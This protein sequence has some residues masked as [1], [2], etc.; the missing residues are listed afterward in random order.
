MSGTA[1]KSSQSFSPI[2]FC[3]IILDIDN[4]NNIYGHPAGNYVLKEVAKLIQL[5]VP[6]RAQAGRIGGDAFLALCVPFSMSKIE[7]YKRILIRNITKIK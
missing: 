5:N 7:R 1:A 4:N 3:A 6:A 2:E